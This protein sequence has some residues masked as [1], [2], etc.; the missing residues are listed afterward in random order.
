MWLL[1][2]LFLLLLRVVLIL[3]VV[4]MLLWLLLVACRRAWFRSRRVC[5]RICYDVVLGRIPGCKR[6]Q[7][8]GHDSGGK[9]VGLKA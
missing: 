5:L 8:A 1:L 2:L 3:V 4:M 7:C 9:D 6:V